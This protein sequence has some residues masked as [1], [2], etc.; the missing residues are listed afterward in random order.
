MWV[1]KSFE[2]FVD[3]L[4]EKIC[5]EVLPAD[6]MQEVGDKEESMFSDFQDCK[7]SLF[8]NFIT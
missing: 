6:L 7:F 8:W 1:I 4:V 3:N 2:E 5:L